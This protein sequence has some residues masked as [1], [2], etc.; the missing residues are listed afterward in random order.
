ML[1]ALDREASPSVELPAPAR[2]Q[3][4]CTL[5]GV[6]YCS[7]PSVDHIIS[8]HEGVAD[9]TRGGGSGGGRGG[10][11]GSTAGDGE[12]TTS[13][14]SAIHGLTPLATKRRGSWIRQQESSSRRGD[15][16]DAH[17]ILDPNRGK[18]HLWLQSRGGWSPKRKAA[19]TTYNGTQK[20]APVPNNI[21]F[22]HGRCHSSAAQ[23]RANNWPS[24]VATTG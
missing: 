4:Y 8:T 21:R 24:Q 3:G 10:I 9:G 12:G 2:A 13:A 18:S 11:T 14:T 19:N 15:D 5:Y 7:H 16:K 20:Y 1:T 6:R 22:A 17:G 23:K